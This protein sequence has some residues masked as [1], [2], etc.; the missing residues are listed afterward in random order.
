ME[1]CTKHIFEIAATQCRACRGMFCEECLVWTHGPKQPPMCIQCALVAGGVRRTGRHARTA[2]MSGRVKIGIAAA[3]TAAAA[4][5]VGP[6]L[7]H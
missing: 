4:A 5:Y 6:A 3:I 2:G 1:N 7:L